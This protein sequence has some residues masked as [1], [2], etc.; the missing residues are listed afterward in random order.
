[1]ADSLTDGNGLRE[2]VVNVK[3]AEL[4]ERRDV[5]SLPEQ[6]M[7]NVVENKRMPD[8]MTANLLG[9]RVVIEGRIGQGKGVR[10]SLVEDCEQRVEEGIGLMSVAVAYPEGINQAS[11]LDGLET[12]I[13]SSTFDINVVTESGTGGWTSGDIGDLADYLRS[14]YGDLVQENVVEEA[15][16]T[17]DDSIDGFVHQLSSIQGISGTEERLH[18]VVIVPNE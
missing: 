17:I 14:G 3:L 9:V 13:L 4:L 7:S 18:E 1:M 11:S 15:V 16:D 2:E 5:V 6:V 12:N 8:I 10:R